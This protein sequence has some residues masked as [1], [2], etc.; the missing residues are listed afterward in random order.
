MPRFAASMDCLYINLNR[1][2]ARRQFL[3]RNFAESRLDGW[4]LSRVEAEDASSLS[5]EPVAG[6]LRNS[7]KACFLSHRKAI[8]QSLRSTGHVMVV[9]DDALFGKNS[10]RNIQTAIASLPESEW[11]LLFTDVC[12]TQANVMFDLFV[13]R[14]RLA[15]DRRAVFLDLKQMPFAGSTAYVVNSGSKAKLLDVL[16]QADPLDTPY[17]LY[18]RSQIRASNLRARVIFPFP[19]SLSELADDSS[20]QV[21][22][23]STPDLIWNAFRRLVWAERDAERSLRSLERLDSDN[24]DAESRAF[25]LILAARMSPRFSSR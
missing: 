4:S 16:G 20:V 17:D 12:I 5:Q 1:Q 2:I 11:D 22:D 9:E 18:L 14:R 7:E 21:D 13:T 6:T 3:E 24:L 8:R 15:E 25:A 19:T 23:A 10:C